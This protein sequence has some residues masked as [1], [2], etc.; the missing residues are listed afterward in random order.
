MSCKRAS[1]EPL[2]A[3]LAGAVLLLLPVF[4]GCGRKGDPLPPLRAPA[5]VEET[6]LAE[7]PT[8]AEEEAAEPEAEQA[9]PDDDVDEDDQDDL[10]DEDGDEDDDGPPP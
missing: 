10:D 3:S 7:A 8:A 9:V 6:A 5:P 4:F 2:S 1:L